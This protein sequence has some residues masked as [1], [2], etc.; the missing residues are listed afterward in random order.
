[1]TAGTSQLASEMEA[2]IRQTQET[3]GQTITVLKQVRVQQG[4]GLAGCLWPVM[5]STAD[6]P[7]DT[8]TSH[9]HH[10]WEPWLGARPS[11]LPPATSPAARWQAEPHTRVLT[12]CLPTSP[13]RP[14][15]ACPAGLPAQADQRL[16]QGLE[17]PLLCAG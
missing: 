9:A 3:K 7:T 2:Y 15:N 1:M 4:G 8:D 13:R 14:P 5:C 17:A 10:R 6:E 11:H 12:C 16:P